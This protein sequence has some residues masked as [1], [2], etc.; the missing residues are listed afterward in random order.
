ML[1]K[2]KELLGEELSKQVEEKLGTVELGVV[3]DGSLVPAEK[4][5]TLKAEHKELK[6]KYTNETTELNQKLDSAIKSATSV[7]A[8][9]S[10]LEEIKIKS[11]E[12]VESLKTDLERSKKIGE[13]K[14]KFI[15]NNVDESYLDIVLSQV[16]LEQ[17][18]V[19]GEN[20]IGVDD[21]A[22]I[23]VE[24]YPKLFG[25][26]KA[27]GKEPNPSLDKPNLT[28]KAKLI[29]KYNE[30]EK[31]T[32][33]NATLRAKQMEDIDRAIKSLSEE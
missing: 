21:V 13:L 10:E 23:V 4:H 5:D 7:E 12:Q 3:N 31:D 32:S 11:Q 24:K 22:K 2:I 33:L 20:V 27:V 9:K 8:L 14:A 16:D 30:L 26:K 28:E 17:L 25:E 19:D 18:K 29:G 6:D 15:A 1:D